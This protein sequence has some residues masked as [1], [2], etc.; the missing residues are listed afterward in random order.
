M[1]E[2]LV[3]G[4]HYPMSIQMYFK[5]AMKRLGH[6]VYSVG[7]FSGESGDIPW[8]GN[9]KFPQYVDKP[10]II[11][12]DSSSYSLKA[13]L[14]SNPNLKPDI[15]W[16]FDAGFRLIGS[17]PY[18]KTVL[19]GTD[20]HA[21]DYRPYY[22]D[23]DYFF[24]AQ[25]VNLPELAEW[26]PLA[27]DPEVHTCDNPINAESRP[28]DVCFIGVYGVPG[29]AGN[30]YLHRLN[31]LMALNDAGL[32]VFMRTGLIFKECTDMYS[33]SKIAYNWSSSWDAA[34]RLWEGCAYG[35]CVVT[36]RIPYL[37]ELG[38]IDGE[39]CVIFETYEELIS[40]TKQVLETGDWKRIAENGNRLITTYDNT[41]DA[42]VE[43]MLK[44]MGYE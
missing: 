37:D 11:L 44:S 9:P 15:V 19:Y 12:P 23:Y 16:S 29:D 6:T 43:T 22:K 25:K 5:R 3:S 36:N 21:L 42:R 1:S 8:P 17:N 38:F 24:S 13:V 30:P 35:C 14:L 7:T 28:I 34:M 41:Y 18:G 39:T 40:K 26:I 20:P 10:D 32:N 31:G 33:Q 2:M 4:R 27:Y